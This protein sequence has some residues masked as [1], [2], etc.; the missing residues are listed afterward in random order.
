[1]TDHPSL[2]P[3]TLLADKFRIE[4]QLG[5]GAMGAVY[6]IRHELTRHKRALKVL[7]PEVRQV[8][9]IVTR[10]IREASAAGRAGNA[11][12]VETFDAG[13]LPEGFPYVVM[14]LLEGE[15]LASLLAREGA[16]DVPR[17]AEI[18]AQA[19]EGIV[20][21]HAAGII[22][23]DLKPENLFVTLR[24][25]EPFVKI[26]DFGVS[27]FL[28]ESASSSLGETQIGAVIGTPLYMSPEQ[29]AGEPNLD[30]RTDVYGLGVILYQ[31]LTGT[32]PFD[33]PTMQAL[34]VRVM[35][36]AGSSV[37][38]LRPAYPPGLVEVVRRTLEPR[39]EDRMASARELVEALG[40]FRPVPRRLS[41]V[42]PSPRSP[43]AAMGALTG[44]VVVVLAVAALTWRMREHEASPVAHRAPAVP[45]AVNLEALAVSPGP[46]SATDVA[47]VTTLAPVE[48]H[49]A[50]ASRAS[51]S[52]AL[53]PPVGPPSSIPSS[54]P[55]SISPAAPPSPP[56]PSPTSKNLGLHQD[57]PFR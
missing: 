27:K 48:A 33:A 25:G 21:A 38:S 36:D 10:F 28:T 45:S 57:N 24:D 30:G 2:P 15:T 3:G 23:R 42:V 41:S 34:I 47:A 51:G 49:P 5:S 11:H 19:A 46:P 16:L 26:L 4:R 55:S 13:T 52:R 8:P 9:E 1:M 54:M 7:H 44:L 32:V 37:D 31:C 43:W 53:R 39:R 20:A 35:R 56:A 17:A 29:L 14:E 40:P 6:A 22:H 12:L 50:F 18:V